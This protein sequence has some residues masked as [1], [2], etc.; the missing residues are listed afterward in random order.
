[1][2]AVH[3]GCA[4][5]AVASAAHGQAAYTTTTETMSC[6]K[7]KFTIAS[8]CRKNGDGLNQCKPQKLTVVS[9]AGTRTTSLPE[10]TNAEAA[11][12]KALGGDIKDLYVIQWG[13]GKSAAKSQPVAVFYY[14]I[15]GGSAPYSEVDI[16]YNEVGQLAGKSLAIAARDYDA[17][18]EAMKP[19]RSIMPRE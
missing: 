16:H 4:M 17:L 9:P 12:Y 7:G 3:L 18:G 10:M 6:G 11:D 1:L 8:T 15:G 5:L 13:C 14:S 2:F 19:V